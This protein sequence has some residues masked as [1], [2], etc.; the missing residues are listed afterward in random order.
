MEFGVLIVWSALKC[1]VTKVWS[2]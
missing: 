1:G 2:T